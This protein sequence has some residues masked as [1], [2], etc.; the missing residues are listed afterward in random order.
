MQSP[1]QNAIGNVMILALKFGLTIGVL[2]GWLW[3]I[4]KGW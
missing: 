1:E 3:L 2:A 4:G